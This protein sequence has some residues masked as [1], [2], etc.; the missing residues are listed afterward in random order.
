MMRRSNIAPDNGEMTGCSG[1]SFVTEITNKNQWKLNLK[2]FSTA[3]FAKYLPHFNENLLEQI[4][5][6]FW[7]AA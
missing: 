6:I 3:N 1:T 5:A 2:I 7:F 4:K